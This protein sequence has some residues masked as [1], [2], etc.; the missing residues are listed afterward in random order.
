MVAGGTAVDTGDGP[1]GRRTVKE[2]YGGA[3]E[4]TDLRGLWA[5]NVQVTVCN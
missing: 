4:F 5:F 2:A 1:G 3:D